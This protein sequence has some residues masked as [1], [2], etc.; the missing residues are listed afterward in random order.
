MR[1]THLACDFG[2][3][4]ALLEQIGG[5]HTPLLHRGKVALWANTAIR[6]PARLLLYRNLDHP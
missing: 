4:H 3:N 5:L 2:R 1:H 6:R